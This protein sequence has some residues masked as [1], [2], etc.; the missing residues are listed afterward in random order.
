MHIDYFSGDAI[1]L[2]R[3]HR[4]AQDV[5]AVLVKNPLVS[6]W[7]MSYSWLRAA[8]DVLEMQGLITAQDEPYPWHKYTVTDAGLAMFEQSGGV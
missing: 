7:D 8:I 6:T 1:D 2:K 5:L 3:G 4:G